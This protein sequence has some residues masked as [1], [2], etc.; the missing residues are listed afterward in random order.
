[1]PYAKG[2]SAKSKSFKEDGEHIETDYL[3]MLKIV[4]RRGLPRLRRHRVRG[5]QAIGAA[6]HLGHKEAAAESAQ[7]LS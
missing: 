5:Q 3:R 6:G 1:M 4:L 2:V 7:E